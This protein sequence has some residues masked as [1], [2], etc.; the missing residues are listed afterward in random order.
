MQDAIVKEHSGEQAPNLILLSDIVSELGAEGTQCADPFFII[1]VAV[2]HH[3]GVEDPSCYKQ[4]HT[5]N[6]E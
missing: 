1:A 5:C 2:A 4:G 3:C 6:K